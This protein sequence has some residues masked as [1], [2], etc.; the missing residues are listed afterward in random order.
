MTTATRAR[1]MPAIRHRTCAKPGCGSHFWPRQ[2]GPHLFAELVVP[3]PGHVV[4]VV[5]RRLGPD[6]TRS[7]DVSLWGGT[8]WMQGLLLPDDPTPAMAD[9]V[10]RARKFLAGATP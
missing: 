6:G 3:E 10:G 1:P 5:Y 4:A 8:N 9:A 7:A 2:H